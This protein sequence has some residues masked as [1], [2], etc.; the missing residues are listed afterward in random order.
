MLKIFI[1]VVSGVLYQEIL[2]LSF[3]TWSH[4]IQ[5]KLGI[6]IL[7]VLGQVRINQRF[8]FSYELAYSV[9]NSVDPDK[10][11]SSEAS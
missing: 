5:D 4:F 2:C 1:G 10:L 11:A 8:C 9:E 3:L 7:L 6:S